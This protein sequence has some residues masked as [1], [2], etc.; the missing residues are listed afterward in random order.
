[1]R[2]AGRIDPVRW[3]AALTALALIGCSASPGPDE[4]RFPTSQD[5][6]PQIMAR[7]N[8]T[9]GGDSGWRLS[10]LETPARAAAWKIVVITGTP[11]WSEYWAP[12]LAK[13]PANRAMI[14]ADR[15]GF[16]DSEPAAA[17]T[18]IAAQAQ[19]LSAM[20]DGPADQ[21]V[22]LIGQ[23]YGGPVATMLAAQRPDKVKALVLMSAFFG[24]RGPT[25]KRL[26]AL[27]AA[28][29]PLL[30][31]DMKNALAEIGAQQPRLPA[32]EQALASLRIPI[33]VLH[34]AKD[35]FVTPDAARTLAARAKAAYVELPEGD[36]FLNACCV[37]GVLA[38]AEQAITAAEAR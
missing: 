24:N 11:S 17:V 2:P 9:A 5:Y 31:R 26:A 29:R 28:T 27:G 10:A 13:V 25:V 1:M 16:A 33:V 7:I 34:G 36:H 18:D 19:A 23:S 3:L 30:P 37:A 12:T 6:G 8:L 22:V 4:K 15:P 21:K 35:T 20:L 14:V 38:A 32:V